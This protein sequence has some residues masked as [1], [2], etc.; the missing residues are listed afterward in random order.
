MFYR[1]R[2][3]ELDGAECGEAHYALSLNT[4]DAADEL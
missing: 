4:S 1:Y 2:L 3:L